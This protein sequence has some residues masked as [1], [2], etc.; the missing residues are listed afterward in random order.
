MLNFIED[1]MKISSAIC[2]DD[3]NKLGYKSITLINELKRHSIMKPRLILKNYQ[4]EEF[5]F[6]GEK[7]IFDKLIEIYNNTRNE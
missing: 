2:L 6:D 7:I 5:I 4:D 3:I 1:I